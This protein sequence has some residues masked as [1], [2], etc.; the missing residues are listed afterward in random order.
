VAAGGW[1]GF[2]GG[3]REAGVDFGAVDG[4][5]VAAGVGDQGQ[6]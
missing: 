1:V 4:D 2:E 5:A 3:V 6:G